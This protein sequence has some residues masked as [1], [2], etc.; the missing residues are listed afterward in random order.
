VW[1]QR[2]RD[3]E[4]SAF[5]PKL[6]V[7]G[8]SSTSF[9]GSSCCFACDG[10]SFSSFSFSS[11]LPPTSQRRTCHHHHHYH[12]TRKNPHDVLASPSPSH[13]F[14]SSCSPSPSPS[15]PFLSSC[16]PCSLH[17]SRSGGGLSSCAWRSCVRCAEAKAKAP[18]RGSS[19]APSPAGSCG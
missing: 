7:S 13:P 3:K 6:Q 15:H 9:Y 10:C 8:A 12:P 5:E 1:T 2:Q 18:T 4:S 11:S 17:P 16:S 19:S 14:L